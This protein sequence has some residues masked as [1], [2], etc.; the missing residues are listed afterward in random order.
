[1]SSASPAGASPKWSSACRSL[2]APRPTQG[3]PPVTATWPAARAGGDVAVTAGF[4]WV[5]RGALK[6]I[7]ALDHF[8]LAPAGEALDI[9]AS[10][11]GFT[12]VLLARGAARVHALDVGH[13]QLDPALAADPRVVSLE[14]VNARALPAEVAARLPPPDWITADV[15]FISLTLA[16]PPALALARPGAHLVGLIKPQFEAGPGH[17]RKGIVRDPAVHAEVCGRIAAF[18]AAGGWQVLGVTT[19]PIAGGDGNREFLVAARLAA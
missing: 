13:G 10:T 8:G 6:L 14:G 5:G 16:L 12:Q 18:L 15:S 3:M 17:V 11:G 9:G 2:S 7:H 19:S 4:P 1:M